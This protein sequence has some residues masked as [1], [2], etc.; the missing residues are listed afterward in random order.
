MLRRPAESVARPA[1]VRMYEK[2]RASP[3]AGAPQT[4][5]KYPDA[6]PTAKSDGASEG[7]LDPLDVGGTT[8]VEEPPP[9]QADKMK[10][11]GAKAPSTRSRLS[12]KNKP[13]PD[14]E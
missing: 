6:K 9:P 1:G 14:N 3:G 12:K 8:E 5:A 13:R 11:P 2:Q 7:P 4:G 10:S